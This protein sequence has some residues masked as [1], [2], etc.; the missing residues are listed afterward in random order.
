MGLDD[1]CVCVLL[2][3]YLLKLIHFPFFPSQNY[4]QVLREFAF[5]LNVG[6]FSF[7]FLSKKMWLRQWVIIWCE[8][9]F[10]PEFIS[11]LFYVFLKLL[12]ALLFFQTSTWS[13]KITKLFVI[14]TF[15]QISA[16]KI[17]DVLRTIEL[18]WI[19]RK[20]PYRMRGKVYRKE[21]HQ[22]SN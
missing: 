8:K 20:W 5:N 1:W 11:H 4:I 7:E 22:D 21:F 13:I 15:N 19:A 18:N 9:M 2:Q 17:F 10:L 3:N 14:L 6:G 12:T 16:H